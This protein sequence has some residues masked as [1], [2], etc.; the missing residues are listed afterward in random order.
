VDVPVQGA[1]TAYSATLSE[2]VSSPFSGTARITNTS[3]FAIP[4]GQPRFL[5]AFNLVGPVGSGNEHWIA[6]GAPAG[7]TIAFENHA[8]PGAT[9]VKAATI[10]T[11]L[12]ANLDWSTFQLGDIQFGSTVVT[13]PARLQSFATSVNTTNP[14]GSPLRVNINASLDPKTGIVTWTFQSIDPNTG[15][16][17]TAPGT[18]F[19]PVNDATN[20]GAVFLNYSVAAQTKL[21]TG[22]QLSALA[23]ITLDGNTASTNTYTNQIDATPPTSTVS[24]L[25]AREKTRKFAVSW[26]GTDHESG[27]ASYDIY[28]SDNG[29][30]FTLWLSGTT[31]TT[32]TFT[33]KSGH[34]YGFYSVAT[35]NVGNRE[36]DPGAAQT[37][38]VA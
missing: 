28:V 34:T 21:A 36:P 19:L 38:T 24:T 20:H 23:S 18:G 26:S 9:T 30:S 27:V 13:V 35:D 22:T 16:P 7:A 10:T 8:N 37:T 4:S 25:P 1:F 12:D 2:T 31:Q 32:P 17:P 5:S 15:Q 14:D 6:A 33:G 29:G 11:Q 3:Q